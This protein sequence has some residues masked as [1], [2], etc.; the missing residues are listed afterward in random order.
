VTQ[1]LERAARPE[2]RELEGQVAFVTGG[3]TGIGLAVARALAARGAAIALFNRNAG[4]A[5][6]AVAAL[7]EQGARARAWPADVADTASVEAAFGAALEA[8]GRV[9]VLVNNAGVTR[10]GVFLR[11][12]D[13]QWDAVLDTNLKGAFRCCRA[14]ARTMMKA[15]YGR[16][17]NISSVVGQ[18]G[19]AGQA[20][21]AAS[22][23]GLL[24]LTRSLARELASR[25]ITVNAVAPGFIETDMTAALPEAAHTELLRGIPLG[26]LGTPAE[27]A[28]VVA[29]LAS[30]RAS[31][32]TGQTWT[33]DGG[34]VMS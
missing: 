12:N 24:G 11:M 30:P 34:M 19:N 16:I 7:T 8:L 5:D 29:F 14:V 15:R 2:G 18:I 32:V 25:A 23:A 22:K 1:G 26:R 27:V 10:D 4:R 28:E 6:A 21:Y 20:N 33:V 3:A 17:V 31:Y 13:A 9:D